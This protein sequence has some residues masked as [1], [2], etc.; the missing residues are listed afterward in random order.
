MK[1]NTDVFTSCVFRLI[2]V[3]LFALL[4]A[5]SSFAQTTP[6]VIVST[7]GYINGTP[8]TVHTSSAFNS[9]GASTLV[10]FVS[11]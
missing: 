3:L 7:V 11:S 5:A 2:T 4:V 6:P 1:T 8:L 10:A 9:S